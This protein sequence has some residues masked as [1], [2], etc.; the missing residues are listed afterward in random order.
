MPKFLDFLWTEPV[1]TALKVLAISLAGAVVE[2][3]VGIIDAIG[4]A[5]LI[6]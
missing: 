1:K 5:P 6:P 2:Y 4:T 3:F